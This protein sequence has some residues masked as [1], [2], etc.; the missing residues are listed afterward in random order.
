MIRK[1]VQIDEAK[2][3]GCGA[4]VHACH[5]QAIALENGVARLISSQHCDGLGDCLPACPMDAIK[6]TVEESLPYDGKLVLERTGVKHQMES[7]LQSWPVQLKLCSPQM[8][9]FE[10]AHLLIAADCT[11]YAYANFHHDFMNKRIPLIACPKLDNIDY[12]IKLSQILTHHNIKSITLVRMEVPC[13]RGLEVALEQ[14]IQLSGYQNAYSVR[15]ISTKG[16]VL[17]CY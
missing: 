9:F 4:C 6:I 16:E 15:V 3:N 7:M 1:I 5:E 14:A 13:C 17:T 11:A 8:S 10:N 12:S 2:C